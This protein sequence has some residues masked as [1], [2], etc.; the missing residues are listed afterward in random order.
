MLVGRLQIFN[1]WSPALVA[2]PKNVWIGLEYFCNEGD[3]L[4]SRTD[5]E[6]IQLAKEELASMNILERGDVLDAT[7]I[8][9][10]KTYPGLLRNL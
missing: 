6:M 10:P 9:V 4:W 1:N 8:R 2:D 5:E 7:V 3:S